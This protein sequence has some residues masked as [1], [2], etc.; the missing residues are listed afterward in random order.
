MVFSLTGWSPQIQ[1]GFLVS[2]LTQ[3]TAVYLSLYVYGIIT[4][5]DQIFQ[6]VPLLTKIKCRSP[7]TPELP[8][9]PRFG[10]FPFRSPLLRESIFLSFPAG[11]KM[12]QFPALAH[13]NM[14]QAFNL[15]GFPIRTPA[16]Q[17]SF[18]NPRSFS[19]LTASFFAHRSLGILRSPL[20]NF[21]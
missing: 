10:L 4:L 1:T 18:A 13:V 7:T 21:L 19:Q 8:Q 3:D 15:T 20:S 14:C 9:Q 6:F 17:L 12:F 16:D 5:F 11:T 2:R